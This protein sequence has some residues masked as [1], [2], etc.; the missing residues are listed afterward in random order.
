ME[1]IELKPI[2]SNQKSFHGRAYILEFDDLDQTK[3]LLSYDKIVA[4]IDSSKGFKDCKILE[5]ETN[6]TLR[7]IQEFLKQENLETGNKKF[8][9]NE[10]K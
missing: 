10:Y 6:S 7:H 9:L 5:I 4:I 1:K 8:L 3:K 2:F